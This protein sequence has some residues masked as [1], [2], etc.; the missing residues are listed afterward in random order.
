RLHINEVAVLELLVVTPGFQP[1]VRLA[2]QARRE[3]RGRRVLGP[4]VALVERE[5]DGGLVALVVEADV[6][7]TPDENAGA[8]HRAAHLEAAD[9]VEVHF[10]AISFRSA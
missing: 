5:R 8:A 6:P 4:L 7:Y 2:E 10:H 3:H 9:V 1:D